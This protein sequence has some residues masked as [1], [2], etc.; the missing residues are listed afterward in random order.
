M[1]LALIAGAYGIRS[2]ATGLGAP[3][4]RASART[5]SAVSPTT[6]NGFLTTAAAMFGDRLFT[7]QTR[8]SAL[9]GGPSAPTV[10]KT[11]QASFKTWLPRRSGMSI[12]SPAMAY[13]LGT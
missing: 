6:V 5:A 8:Q 4:H 7:H 3:S 12:S 9:D 1:S 2:A 13:A 11:R 10:P